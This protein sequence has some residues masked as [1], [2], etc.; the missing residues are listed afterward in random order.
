MSIENFEIAYVTQDA[1]GKE[2]SRT[3]GTVY[4]PKTPEELCTLLGT[5]MDEMA[6][7]Q[8]MA[9]DEDWG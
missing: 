8:E 5:T 6:E 4:A 9:E 7:A 3:T 2:I 1:N